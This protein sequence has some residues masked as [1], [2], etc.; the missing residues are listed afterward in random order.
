LRFK[1]SALVQGTSSSK[2]SRNNIPPARSHATVSGP[3]TY[4]LFND[5]EIVYIKDFLS[6]VE[7]EYM[8]GL[9]DGRFAPSKLYNDDGTV[10]EDSSQRSSLSAHLDGH[11]E[12]DP[13]IRSLQMRARRFP[14]Y[15]NVGPFL[16]M[17]VQNYGVNAEYQLHTDWFTDPEVY[18]GNVASTFFVYIHANCTG[19]GTHFP[20]L[21]MTKS[22]RERWCDF[23]ECD[24]PVEEGITFK[25]VR[26][27]AV[28]F[29][30]LQAN[31]T[32]HPMTIHAGMPVTSGRKMGMNIW[33]WE[34]YQGPR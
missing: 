32:G 31:G 34:Y 9:T 23:V 17:T 28:F 12:N 14:F 24:K 27:N 33:T 13:V 2:T 29:N 7:A 21:K 20:E 5:P 30:N 16:P 22:E 25:P 3:K 8:V 26:G 11:L 6:P 4:Q 15:H 19:G 10:F 1:E 18:G